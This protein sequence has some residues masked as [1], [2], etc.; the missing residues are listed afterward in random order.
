MA[1]T[2]DPSD[3][4]RRW[5]QRPGPDEICDAIS[6]ALDAGVPRGTIKAQLGLP[7]NQAGDSQYRRWRDRKGRRDD[8][9][10]AGKAS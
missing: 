2:N 7:P 9:P 6:A 3:V 1:T 8:S 4:F 10:R 5:S